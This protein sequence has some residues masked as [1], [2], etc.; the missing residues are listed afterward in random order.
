MPLSSDVVAMIGSYNELYPGQQATPEV[1]RSMLKELREYTKNDENLVIGKPDDAYMW[2]GLDDDFEGAEHLHLTMLGPSGP[3]GP[4]TF[5]AKSYDATEEGLLQAIVDGKEFLKRYHRDGV[6]ECKK[7]LYWRLKLEGG[8][9]C[10]VCTA[11][12]AMGISQ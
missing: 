5:D 8:T 2:L 11:N 9:H 1:L 3:G 4:P 10:L 7:P 6:C 12:K